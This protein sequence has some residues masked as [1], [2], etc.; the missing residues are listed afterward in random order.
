QIEAM[1]LADRIVVMNHGVIEQVGSPDEMYNAPRT[2]FVA[3][4][5]GSPAMNFVPCH[6][7]RAA[8]GLSVRVTDDVTLTVPP[9]RE[10]RYERHAGRDLLLGIRPEH[11]THKRAHTHEDFQDFAAPVKVLEPMGMDTM[12]FFDLGNTEVCSRS[13]PKATGNVGDAMGFTIDKSQMHLIDPSTSA[14]L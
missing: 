14:V 5:I 9:D 13:D 7:D 1:T 11:L 2:H 4:F 8:S 3:S 12:V 6:L 10:D